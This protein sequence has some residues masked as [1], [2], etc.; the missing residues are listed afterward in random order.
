MHAKFP[1]KFR[2]A[3][4]EV[5][6]AS[7]AITPTTAP[8]CVLLLQVGPGEGPP[9]LR[10][11]RAGVQGRLHR[12]AAAPAASAR[13]RAADD[14]DHHAPALWT[15]DHPRRRLCGARGGT[16]AVRRAGPVR[17]GVRVRVYRVCACVC[18]CA[19]MHV[20]ER[21]LVFIFV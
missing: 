13:R 15:H 4:A 8:S 9:A 10:G 20:F 1:K 2:I 21:V 16:R 3:G 7:A 11:V 19:R 17:P 5:E 18:M 6:S 12:P 14:R